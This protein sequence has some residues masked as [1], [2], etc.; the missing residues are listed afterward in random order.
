MHHALALVHPAAAP[1][2]ANP[3]STTRS[4]LFAVSTASHGG[5]TDASRQRELVQE[6]RLPHV[7]VPNQ[8]HGGLQPA[9]SRA[10]LVPAPALDVLEEPVDLGRPVTQQ[11]ALRLDGLLAAPADRVEASALAVVAAV[12]ALD[13]VARLILE[14]RELDLVCRGAR[15]GGVGELGARC[16]DPFTGVLHAVHIWGKNQTNPAEEEGYKIKI[17]GFYDT[18]GG[19]LFRCPRCLWRKVTHW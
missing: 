15:T 1:A 14:P 13:E 18:L 3:S 16:G 2:A 11:P 10:P 19:C 17:T 8:G 4:T 7:R 5:T 9:I 12:G 6:R